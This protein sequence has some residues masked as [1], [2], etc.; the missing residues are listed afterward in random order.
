MRAW[1]I[2]GGFMGFLIGIL[3][4]LA[5]GSAW[6]SVIWKASVA[7]LLAGLLMRWW[8]RVW[9]NSIRDSHRQRPSSEKDDGPAGG[10]TTRV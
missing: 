2:L 7:T 9:I 1:M 8:G 6:P 10:G 3:F 4:G 5:Q